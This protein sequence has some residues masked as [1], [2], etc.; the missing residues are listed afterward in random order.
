MHWL[1]LVLAGMFEIA[2]ATS[3]KL[4]DNFSKTLPV[5]AFAITGALSFW[6]LSLSMKQIPIGTA[7]A[8]WTGIGAFGTAIVG[9]IFFND[10]ATFLRIFFLFTLIGSILGL[11]MVSTI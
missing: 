10:S 4:S 7:Y 11:K 8:I 3:L 9:I 6:L 5:I 1:F 2:M